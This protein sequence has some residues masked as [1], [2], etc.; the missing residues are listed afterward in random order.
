MRIADKIKESMDSVSN[1]IASWDTALIGLVLGK[2]SVDALDTLIDYY[3]GV[4]QWVN[5]ANVK[6]IAEVCGYTSD[7][8]NERTKDFLANIPM[9]TSAP[10]PI[11]NDVGGGTWYAPDINVVIN[12]YRW[13]RELKYQEE[14][15]DATAAFR[16]LVVIRYT[17]D[18]PFFGCNP[19]AGTFYRV[20]ASGRWHESAS[21]MHTF[22][23]FDKVNAP[24]AYAY[25]LWEWGELNRIYWTGDH[26]NYS[27]DNPNWEL[28]APTVHFYNTKMYVYIGRV[29]GEFHRVVEDAEARYLLKGWGS[30]QWGGYHVPVHHNP[31]NLQRSLDYYLPAM[32]L[33]HM[34]YPRMSDDGKANFKGMLDGSIAPRMADALLAS[35]LYVAPRFKS[36]SDGSVSDAATA[37]GC[38]TLFLMG[39]IPDTGSLAVPVTIEGTGQRDIC[40]LSPRYFGFDYDARKVKIPVY[41]GKIR[42]YLGD[43][44]IEYTFPYDGVYT[45]TFGSDWNSITS[46]QWISQ[47]EGN[48]INA[49]SPPPSGL[50][51]LAILA[52]TATSIP[53]IIPL[54]RKLLETVK[55]KGEEA[56]VGGG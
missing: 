28:A 51:T 19:D 27:P 49:P 10:I 7:T 32:G 40:F 17:Q 11:N 36:R 8:I 48:F 30:P 35:D 47:L 16:K 4:G 6:A 53:L 38:A 39:I 3:A 26:F 46:A 33:L 25:M 31:S 1:W 42:F 56:V 22:L 55:E 12:G 20:Y 50:T 45:V 23:L 5:V 18:Y 24:L 29:L 34:L 9:F 14:R 52:I 2:C 21:M 13:A 37:D 15:W 54:A 43:T 44:P 41:A